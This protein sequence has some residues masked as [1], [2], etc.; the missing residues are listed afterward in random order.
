M[1]REN[2]ESWTTG[3]PSC[4]KYYCIVED[5]IA[6]VARGEEGKESGGFSGDV[7]AFVQKFLRE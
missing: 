4:L 3:D 6:R 2:F 5:R 7:L 1:N